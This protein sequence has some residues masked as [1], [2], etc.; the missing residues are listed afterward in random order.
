MNN[1]NK[2][3]KIIKRIDKIR[4]EELG[5]LESYYDLIVDSLSEEQLSYY[6]GLTEQEAFYNIKGN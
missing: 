6:L 5:Q 1:T 3:L 2:K 4:V